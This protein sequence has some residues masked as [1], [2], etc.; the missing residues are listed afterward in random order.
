LVTLALYFAVRVAQG[1][2]AGSTVG[3]GLAFGA[4]AA[5]KISVLSFLLIIVAAYGWR[6]WVRWRAVDGPA[7]GGETDAAAG[8][9][10]RALHAVTAPGGH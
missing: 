7:E 8:W 9:E 6:L 3:L 2:G 4:A 5:A 1:E 10:R